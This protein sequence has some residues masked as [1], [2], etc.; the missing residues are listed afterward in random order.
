ML[1]DQ[2]VATA[3][4]SAKAQRIEDLSP[5][6]MTPISRETECSIPDDHIRSSIDV[7]ANSAKE[8]AEKLKNE[9]KNRDES[10][11][12]VDG[13]GMA[14]VVTYEATSGVLLRLLEMGLAKALSEQYL[15]D[16]PLPR[17]EQSYSYNYA[18]AEA[19]ASSLTESLGIQFYPHGYYD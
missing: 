10:G 6:E 5:V 17:G 9:W 15:I 11:Q 19:A 8:A 16:I 18:A 7:A 4:A 13:C 3:E 1:I 2:V 12:M 14:H